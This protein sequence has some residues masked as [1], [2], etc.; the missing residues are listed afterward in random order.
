ME[1]EG[2]YFGEEEGSAWS[3]VQAGWGSPQDLLPDPSINWRSYRPSSSDW[4]FHQR[5]SHPH[6][7]RTCL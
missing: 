6:P 2:T 1:N 3:P 4:W 5:E 7:L